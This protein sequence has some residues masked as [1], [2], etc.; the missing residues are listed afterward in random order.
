M[1]EVEGVQTTENPGVFILGY[2]KDPK[3]HVGAAEPLPMPFEHAT[4]A[5]L[6]PV[7]PDQA[8]A[9]RLGK[10]WKFTGDAQ[11]S[12][13]VEIHGALDGHLHAA[14]DKTVVD[15]A[16][17]GRIKGQVTAKRVSVAGTLDGDIHAQGGKV[18]LVAG[19]HVSGTV[20]YEFIEMD[21][22]RG[23]MH[24]VWSADR[25]EDYAQVQAA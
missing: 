13:A 8:L 6:Q 12:D 4:P 21:N 19:A 23:N 2:Q 22:V 7:Q 10:A 9:T 16:A 20:T 3:P 5:A 24:L 25:A 14:D 17:T 1:L 11:V 18:V 15:I